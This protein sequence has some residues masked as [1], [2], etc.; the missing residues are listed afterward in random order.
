ALIDEEFTS[1]HGRL[2]RM[3]VY[4]DRVTDKLFTTI[5]KGSIFSSYRSLRNNDAKNQFP[6]ENL[7]KRINPLSGNE[8]KRDRFR[9]PSFM[10]SQSDSP[11]SPSFVD[12]LP[13]Q[14][15]NATIKRRGRKPAITSPFSS[16]SVTRSAP[17]TAA[18]AESAGTPTSSSGNNGADANTAGEL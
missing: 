9:M 18:A 17:P 8:I 10:S 16:L 4:Q 6:E 15:Q 7:T 13:P 11:F 5:S 14:P 1:R 3:N 2:V 12:S